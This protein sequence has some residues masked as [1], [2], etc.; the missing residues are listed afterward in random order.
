M[1]TSTKKPTE[2]NISIFRNDKYYHV[3]RFAIVGDDSYI[4]FISKYRKEIKTSDGNN[5]FYK[6]APDHISYHKDGKIHIKHKDGSYH[7][8][9]FKL[10]EKFLTKDVNYD[11]PWIAIT[12][13]EEAFKEHA[14]FF[15]VLEKKPDNHIIVESHN[16]TFTIL[17]KLRDLSDIPLEK[18]VIDF[19]VRIGGLIPDK[20]Y[21]NLLENETNIGK[22]Y[23]ILNA[24]LNPTNEQMADLKLFGQ[25][26]SDNVGKFHEYL[27]KTFANTM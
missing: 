10:P 26:E 9:P 2:I 15:K 27:S 1:K 19:E 14:P 16:V 23:P 4:H 8:L 21:P 12:F 5:V 17:V 13:Y 6:K 25:N 11:M 22:K 3:L 24:C 20:P 7:D 18:R